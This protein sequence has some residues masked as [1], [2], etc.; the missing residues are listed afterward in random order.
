LV[1]FNQGGKINR[2]AWT[3]DDWTYLARRQ[4]LGF[5]MYTDRDVAIVSAVDVYIC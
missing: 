2:A 5:I 4:D 3:D 1:A